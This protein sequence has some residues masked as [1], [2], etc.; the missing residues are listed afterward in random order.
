MSFLI[1]SDT[2]GTME[3]AKVMR[4]FE[5]HPGEYTK[6]DYLII[7]GDVAACGFSSQEELEVRLALKSLPVTTLFIDGNHENFNELDSY[8]VDIWNGGKVH[9]IESDIIH[10]MRGQVFEID[11]KSFFTFGGGYSVDKSYRK[12]GTTWFPQE[13]PSPEEYDEGIDNLLY[14]GF[15][16]DYVISHS[17]PLD[18][19]NELLTVELAE[20]EKPL[21]KYLQIISENTNFKAWY[22]G[23]FHKDVVIKD[24]F[25]CLYEDIVKL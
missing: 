7:C 17:G 20:Q 4:Y 1:A 9:I 11:G 23:H 13:L 19:V 5:A 8:Y 21:C 22:F 2:H 24:K 12:E 18:V 16:V 14:A 15:K 6:D 10:L 3:L 25:F